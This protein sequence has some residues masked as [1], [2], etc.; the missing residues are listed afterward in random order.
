LLAS[1][2]RL[3]GLGAQKLPQDMEDRLTMTE[4]HRIGEALVRLKTAFLDGAELTV[5]QASRIAGLDMITCLA[6]LEALE[7]ARV[8]RRTSDRTFVGREKIA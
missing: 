2:R 6:L 3:V 7:Q 1:P 8:L 5:E 4:T